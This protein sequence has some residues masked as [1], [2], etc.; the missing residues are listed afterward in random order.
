MKYSIILLAIALVAVSCSKSKNNTI[1]LLIGN[2]Y[3]HDTIYLNE[4]A[5]TISVQG[6]ILTYAVT[7]MNPTGAVTLYSNDSLVNCAAITSIGADS[8]QLEILGP[9]YNHNPHGTP[10]IIANFRIGSGI[11]VGH[12]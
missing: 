8:T 10:F 4:G 1:K 3:V 11:Y 5:S 6:R 7:T 2:S 12:N 9:P